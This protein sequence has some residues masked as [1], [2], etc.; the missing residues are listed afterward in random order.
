MGSQ[1]EIDEGHS[2]LSTGKRKEL[3]RLRRQNLTPISHNSTSTPERNKLQEERVR[4]GYHLEEEPPPEE[5]EPPE[6][7]PPPEEWEE[8]AL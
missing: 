8:L 1:A 5:W 7:E 3:A 4:N 2:G 6:E